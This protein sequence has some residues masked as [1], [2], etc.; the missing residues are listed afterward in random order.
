MNILGAGLLGL[1]GVSGVSG[2]LFFKANDRETAVRDTVVTILFPF[3]LAAGL[4]PTLGF[5]FFDRTGLAGPYQTS[6]AEHIVGGLIAGLVAT[7]IVRHLISIPAGNVA[8]FFRRK[9]AGK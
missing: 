8:E 2:A 7:P 5:E 3:L 9:G 4:G 1:A 6:V